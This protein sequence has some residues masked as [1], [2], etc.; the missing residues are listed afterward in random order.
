[1]T[2]LKIMGIM[3]TGFITSVV[4]Y[5]FTR[6][7]DITAYVIGVLTIL[8]GFC[9]LERSP[10]ARARAVVSACAVGLGV[11]LARV[12]RNLLRRF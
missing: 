3:A 1:M 2:Y 12:L 9:V 5:P 4:F 7:L 11:V 6:V 8:G 10:L